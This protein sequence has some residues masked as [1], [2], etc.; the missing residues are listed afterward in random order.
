MLQ[1]IKKLRQALKQTLFSESP[2]I[3][4]SANPANGKPIGITE[5]I[6]KISTFSF[7]PQRNDEGPFL[8]AIDHCFSIK[9]QGT[10]MTGTIL[11]GAV[12]LNDVRHILLNILLL[13][14]FNCSITNYSLLLIHNIL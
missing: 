9:G 6:E 3:D 2:I 5:L 14:I 7:V 8:F 4:I 1:V 13:Y 11:Q 10:V 12:K